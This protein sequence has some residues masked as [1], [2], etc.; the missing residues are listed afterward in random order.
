MCKKN[1]GVM[2]GFVKH[3]TMLADSDGS[4]SELERVISCLT[5]AHEMWLIEDECRSCVPVSQRDGTDTY[6][7]G[8]DNLPMSEGTAFFSPSLE[9]S[10]NLN[11]Y[12]GYIQMTS[13]VL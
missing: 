12:V 13:R 2:S 11:S 5:D 3:G 1:M 10:Q 4:L 7:L 6:S 9:I 8:T